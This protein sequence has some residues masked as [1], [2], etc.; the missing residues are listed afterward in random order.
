MEALHMSGALAHTLA[1][2]LRPL[3]RKDGTLD[4]VDTRKHNIMEHDRSPTRLDFR[5]GDNWTMQPKMLEAM[6]A[7]AKGGDMTIHTISK[8]YRRRQSEHIASGGPPLSWKLWF[9]NLLMTVSF[10]N[11]EATGHP[12]PENVRQFWTEERWQD[13][14]LHDPVERTLHGL[15]LRV[16]LLLWYLVVG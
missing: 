8:T 7:D 1:S 10:I 15:L 13:Y 16:G 11:V 2:G 12:S 5:Q 4:L 6:L 9:T 3:V 14:V